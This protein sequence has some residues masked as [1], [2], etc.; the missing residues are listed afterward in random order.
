[1]LESILSMFFGVGAAI[2]LAADAYLLAAL[3]MIIAGLLALM[4]EPHPL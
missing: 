2:A 4:R 3:C 1:M